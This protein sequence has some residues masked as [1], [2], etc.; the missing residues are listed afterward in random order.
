M[1]RGNNLVYDF[2][3]LT[4]DCFMCLVKNLTATIFF[5]YSKTFLVIR[6]YYMREKHFCHM[7][8]HQNPKTALQNQYAEFIVAHMGHSQL[9]HMKNREDCQ[10]FLTTTSIC[11]Y[12]K[13]VVTRL[14]SSCQAA[15]THNSRDDTG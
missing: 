4:P 3:G 9:T 14:T 7:N 15:F 8:L 2:T 1:Q 12:D 10:Y 11:H 5:D 13:L 6:N